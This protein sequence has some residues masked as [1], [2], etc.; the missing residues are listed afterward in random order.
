M[1]SKEKEMVYY[2]NPKLIEPYFD[3]VGYENELFYKFNHELKTNVKISFPFK[4]TLHIDYITVLHIEDKE[5]TVKS[6]DTLVNLLKINKKYPKIS[7]PFKGSFASKIMVMSLAKE[8]DYLLKGEYKINMRMLFGN[9]YLYN[10]IEQCYYITDPKPMFIQKLCYL[11]N[12]SYIEECGI[13]KNAIYP[14]LEILYKYIVAYLKK[15]YNI[16]L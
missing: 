4:D 2:I 9:T 16:E 13:N 1:E 7:N 15:T 3:Y 10:F 12:P 6:L 14:Q 5:Y 11:C 8:I